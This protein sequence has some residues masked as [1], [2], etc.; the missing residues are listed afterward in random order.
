MPL[1]SVI[2]FG[3]NNWPRL[4][5]NWVVKSSSRE[6]QALAVPAQSPGSK[7]RQDLKPAE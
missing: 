7:T 5:L 4:K 6:G 2:E 3:E 1:A